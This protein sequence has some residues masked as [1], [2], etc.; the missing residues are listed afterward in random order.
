MA[1]R[2][3]ASKLKKRKGATAHP[4]A[5]K[6]SKASRAKATKRTV[7]KTK[8]KRA[9]VKT[10][11]RKVKRPVT[12]VVETV[13][14]EVIEQP[15]PGVILSRKSRRHVKRAEPGALRALT[16]LGLGQTMSGSQECVPPR[17]VEMASLF[18]R[19]AHHPEAI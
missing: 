8:P 14:V 19:R 16:A 1:K 5:R 17:L 7:A 4:K 15:A 9:P 10:A 6:L 12:P 13:A 3:K 18:L 2:K 11:A